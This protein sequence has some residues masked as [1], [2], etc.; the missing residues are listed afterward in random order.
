MGAGAS[1]EGGR[2]WCQPSWKQVEKKGL[3]LPRYPK[4]QEW[5]RFLRLETEYGYTEKSLARRG[6]FFN[7]TVILCKSHTCRA[8]RMFSS[9]LQCPEVYLLSSS[10][11]SSVRGIQV[12]RGPLRGWRILRRTSS[13]CTQWSTPIRSSVE[14]SHLKCLLRIS[15]SSKASLAIFTCLPLWVIS[16]NTSNKTIVLSLWEVV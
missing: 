4:L 11:C 10:T 15:L 13:K 14:L 8:P 12:H 5:M 3:K 1:P 6:S 9:V 2:T 16:Y 7:N